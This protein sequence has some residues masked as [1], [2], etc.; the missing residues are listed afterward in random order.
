MKTLTPWRAHELAP[1]QDFHRLDARL[2]NMLGPSWPETES[3]MGWAPAIDVEETEGA[4]EVTAELPGMK[5]EDVDATV[6]NDILTIRGEKKQETRKEEEGGKWH[7]LERTY[8]S[9]ARS[10]TLPR[11][12]NEAK[13]EARFEDGVLKVTLPKAEEAKSRK[14]RIDA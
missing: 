14:I 3:A 6:E 8:G 4:Y 9:F 11:R 10:F 7:L 12:V 1:W 2:R 5:A 13:V